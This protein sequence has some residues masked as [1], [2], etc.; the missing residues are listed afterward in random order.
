MS[1]VTASNLNPPVIWQPV[2]N[3]IQTTGAVFSTTLPPKANHS[4]F[5]RLQS[6]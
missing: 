1:L 2:T 5:Y 6:N 3:P 4:R